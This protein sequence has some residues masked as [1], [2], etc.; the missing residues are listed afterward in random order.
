MQLPPIHIAVMQP[1][2]YIY[3]LAF[4]D[5]A[6]YFRHQFRRLGAQVTIG[7]NRLR[8]DA[9]N[10][11]FG[12]HLGFPADGA[13]R[14]A[15]VFVNLEQLGEGGAAVS[16]AYLQLLAGS[17]VVDY[18]ADNVAAYAANPADVPI[19]P[20]LHAP[21]LHD[22]AP[23]PLAE[24]PIDLLFF[25]SVNE[26]RQAFLQHAEASG[27]TVACFD[28]ALFVDERDDYIRRAKAVINC[29]FYDTSRFEQARVFQCL[30]LGTPV[31]SERT[32][33]TRAPAAYDDAVFWLNDSRQAAAFFREQFG[34]PAFYAQAERKLAAFRRHD[35]KDAYAELLAFAV[36]YADTHFRLHPQQIWQ[37]AE[38]HAGSGDAYQTGWLNVSAEARTQPDLA[39]DL[40]AAAV[41]LPLHQPTLL[42]GEVLLQAGQLSRV[43]VSE[44]PAEPQ[45]FGTLMGNAL[46]L[47]HEGGEAVVD[48]PLSSREPDWAA[49]CRE[50]WRMGWMTERFELQASGWLD[51]G[52]RPCAREQA[53]FARTVLR[54]MATTQHERTLARTMRA[55]FGSLPDDLAVPEIVEAAEVEAQVVEAATQSFTAPVAAVPVAAVPLAAVPAAAAAPAVA[56]PAGLPTMQRLRALQIDDGEPMPVAAPA[57]AAA[58]APQPRPAA[59][60]PALTV[61]DIIRHKPTAAAQPAAPAPAAPQATPTADPS[62]PAPKRKLDDVF[63]SLLN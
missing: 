11:V 17:A 2:S 4:I 21:Y 33:R 18:D 1:A 25:G 53:E 57:A 7:K 27:A 49:V 34:T 51:V 26:R 6:R 59:T 20:F 19:V 24:R 50:F 22:A 36:A 15:C 43:Y 52:R 5:H 29:H 54:K 3:S 48:L 37:P 39:L 30:S 38:L 31:I 14:H 13:Q 28:H 58:T 46:A 62:A 41:E 42:G 40:A 8:E 47:L 55:D 44:L 45:A 35:P 23:I 12:A 32:P 16:P 60:R 10:F 61:P 56:A 63:A 9:V